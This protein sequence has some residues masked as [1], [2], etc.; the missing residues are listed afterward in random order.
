MTKQVARAKET[1]AKVPVM[2]T[3]P[4][5]SEP[6]PRAETPTS[7]NIISNEVISA[8]STPVTVPRENSK[9]I[10]A[11]AKQRAELREAAT[12]YLAQI[13][14]D[15]FRNGTTPKVMIDAE[16]YKIGEVIDET[17]GL[18]FEGIKDGKLLFKDRNELYYLKSF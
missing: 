2:D 8:K 4:N 13:H 5:I 7:I 11:N 9:E 15:G 1:I 17:T 12:L 18:S 16:S 14:I 3:I 10:Q 6:V